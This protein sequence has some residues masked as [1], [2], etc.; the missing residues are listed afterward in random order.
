MKKNSW[1]LYIAE[2]S[3]KKLYVG[4]TTDVI[5]RI[6]R[7]NSGKGCRFTKYRSP[8]NLLHTEKFEIKK[9]AEAREKEVKRFS[10]DKK[11]NLIKKASRPAAS[12]FNSA[13]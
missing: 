9:E 1:F 2:C 10:R 4:I 6:K 7:H 3:D 8:L 12:M 5:A 11:L 13:R